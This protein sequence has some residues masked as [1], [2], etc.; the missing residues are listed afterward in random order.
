MTGFFFRFLNFQGV[1]CWTILTNGMEDITY[2]NFI[3]HHIFSNWKTCCGEIIYSHTDGWITGVQ[4]CYP[5]SYTLKG[6]VQELWEIPLKLL[7][8][9]FSM[10]WL[11]RA[12]INPKKLHKCL[13]AV[14]IHI[15]ITLFL[16][17]SKPVQ[18][19]LLNLW[20]RNT[21]LVCSR[22]FAWGRVS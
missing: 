18:S 16:R 6:V 8:S 10:E 2:W 14:N 15:S 22:E 20:F 7:S 21:I 9:Y 17:T 12:T 1:W 19:S 11:Q 4:L 5:L 3:F 13:A